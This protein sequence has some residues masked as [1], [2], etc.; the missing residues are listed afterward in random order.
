[1]THLPL[2]GYHAASILEKVSVV[3]PEAIR[4]AVRSLTSVISLLAACSAG[5]A[6]SVDEE[7]AI[8]RQVMAEVR[9]MGLTADP[10]LSV[11][12]QRLA[13]GVERD[14]IP[15]RF[16]VIE[17]MD[18]YNAFA[19]PGGPVFI[20]RTYYQMLSE[21]EAAFVVGHEMAHIDLLH[22]ERQRKRRRKAQLGHL[23]LNILVKGKGSSTLRTATNLGATAYMTHYSRALE[24]EADFAGYRYAEEGGYDAR[25]AVTALRKLG[26]Q[27]QLHPWIINIYATH[28]ILSSREDRL[29][30]MGGEEPEEVQIPEPSPSHKRDLAGGLRPMEP[31]TP[32]A[33]RILAPEGDRWE[34]GWRKSFTKH[35]HQRLTPLGFSIAGDDIMYKPDIGD[36]VEAARSRDAQYLLLVTVHQMESTKI[37][38]SELAGTPVRAAID[39][40]PV[41]IV[42]ADGS[43]LWQA[44]FWEQ[45][46]GLD[47][48]SVD[49]EILYTD[50]SL[51]AV[52]ERV[53]GKIAIGCATAAG[54]QPAGCEGPTE[55]AG[56][57][58]PAL[59]QI[60]ANTT[61]EER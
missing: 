30:A 31:P 7:V 26:E 24:K 44:R 47:V 11:I 21:D 38:K 45:Q 48:L 61:G 8:G 2:G 22:Y 4:S 9:T 15:W 37:G 53:A 41:L 17:G 16:W 6:L 36:P 23:L 34:G 59:S 13:A 39:A 42:I 57:A 60:D 19:A 33:V 50:A 51:G 54:A 14:G 18:S 27:P 43:Q 40:E 52:A 10:A 55:E 5:I 20:S 28:P 3:G 56:S 35:L 29:A 25:L 12:G 49:P 32:V 46:E 58:C 1:L